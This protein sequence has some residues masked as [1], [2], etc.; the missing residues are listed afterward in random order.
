MKRPISPAPTC[1]RGRSVSRAGFT[2]LEVLVAL[3][4]LATLTSVVCSALIASFRAEETAGRLREAQAVLDRVFVQEMI[5]LP[6]GPTGTTEWEVRSATVRNAGATGTEW[7]VHT[8]YASDRPSLN[9][10]AAHR[11]K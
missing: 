2:F 8:V 1:S 11:V 3:V 7:R 5:D 6:G 10:V 9:I 4:V